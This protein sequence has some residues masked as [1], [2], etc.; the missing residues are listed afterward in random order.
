MI[1]KLKKNNRFIKF[2]SN[3]LLKKLTIK[4]KIIYGK[5]NQYFTEYVNF[6]KIEINEILNIHNVF[7]SNYIEDCKNFK[8]TKNYKNARNKNFQLDRIHYDIILI[9]SCLLLPH[10]FKIINEVFNFNYK[11]NNALFVG[12]GSGLEIFL[13][14]DKISNYDA[15]DINISSFVKKKFKNNINQKIFKF[16]KKNYNYIFAIELLEHLQQ[17]YIL[18]TE[19][20]KSLEKNGILFSTTA[21]NIPQFDHHYNFTNQIKFEDKI[22]QIGFKILSKKIIKHLGFK[23]N[24]NSNNIFY[25]LQ[26]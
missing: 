24:L 17:P 20:Y 11:N 3:Q 15:Y 26:K 12:I 1:N 21:K 22:K 4:E 25:R 7:V 6:Y 18:I 2:Q 19:F 23:D 10:R 9:L 16:N 13:L 5:I 14:E 8:K